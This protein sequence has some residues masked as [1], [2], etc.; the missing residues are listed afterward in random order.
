MN[1]SINGFNTT[2]SGKPIPPRQAPYVAKQITP[3]KVRTAK[4]TEFVSGGICIAPPS[5]TDKRQTFRK[6]AI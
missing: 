3:C 6:A 5:D 4:A 1:N 2:L